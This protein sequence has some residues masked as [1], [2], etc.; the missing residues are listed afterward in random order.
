MRAS[1]LA[2]AAWDAWL[3]TVPP[4]QPTLDEARVLIGLRWQIELIFKRWKS[5]GRVDCSRSRQPYRVLTEVYAKLVAPLVRHGRLLVRGG[6]D[7]RRSPVKAAAMVRQHAFALLLACRQ[8]RR[9]IAA[10]TTLARCLAHAGQ[11]GKRRKQ[12]ATADRLLALPFL[13]RLN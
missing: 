2:L 11:V 4:D 10:L 7:P 9:L 3:T 12:P 6:D 8:R 13:P 5:G 1:R